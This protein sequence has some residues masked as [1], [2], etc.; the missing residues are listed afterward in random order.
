MA[1]RSWLNGALVEPAQALVSAYDHGLVVGDGV[2]E[3][4][5]VVDGVPFALTRHLARLQRSARGLGLPEVDLDAVR[6]AAVAVCAEP[7]LPAAARL[8]IT[9]T[10]GP[11]PLGSGRGDGPSTLFVAAAPLTPWSP[12]CAVATVPW[13][14]NERGALVGVKTTSYAENVVALDYARSREA[15]EAVFANTAGNLCE[16]TGSN[17][18]VVLDERLVTPPLSAGCLAGVTRDLVLEWVDGAVEEDVPMSVLSDA[19]A[20]EVFLTSTTRDVQPVHAFDGRKVAAAPGPVTR[21]AMDAFAARAA[22]NPDPRS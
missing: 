5:K 20:G 21:R 1:M 4:C 22:D 13:P 16:G 3:T 17:V 7:D 18:F 12:T 10:A 19:A 8:R 11:A 15:A 6:A 14:R 2:F 9:V